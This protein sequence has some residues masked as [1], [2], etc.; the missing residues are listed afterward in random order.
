MTT[1]RKPTRSAA[2][3]VLNYDTLAASIEASINEWRLLAHEAHKRG[4]AIGAWE[5][6][7]YIKDLEKRRSSMRKPIA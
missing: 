7:A 4:D 3:R 5:A 6:A 1:P 2:M